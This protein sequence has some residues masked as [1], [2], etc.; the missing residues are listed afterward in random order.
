MRD[1]SPKRRTAVV[2]TGSGAS[3]AYHAGVL[4]ALDESGVKIDLVVGSGIGTLAA[5]FAAIAGGARLYGADG[6]WKAVGWRS[7]YRMRPILRAALWLLAAILAVIVVPAALALLVGLLSPLILLAWLIAS[8]F[9]DGVPRWVGLDLGSLPTLY[10]AALALPAFGLALVVGAFVARLFLRDRRRMAEAFEAILDERPAEERLRATLWTVARGPVVSA[11]APS[12]AELSK[13]YT[14]LLAENLGQPGFR[15][16]I[17]RAANLETC[18]A[19]PFVLLEDVHRAAFAAARSRGARV[20]GDGIPG[21][22][23]LRRAG[24]EGL[25]F[26][27]TMTG[28]LPLLGAPVRRIA[29]PRGGIHAGEVHRLADAALVGGSGLSEA[30][31]AGAQ[32]V[33][34]VTGVPGEALV[35]PRR[36]GPRALADGLLAALER[37]AVDRDVEGAE[38]INRMVETLGHRNE[39]GGRGWEDPATGR[40]YRDIALYVIRPE[41]RTLGPLELDGARDPASEVIE[42][43]DDLAERGYHDAYRLFVEPVVGGGEPAPRVDR[44]DAEG[45]PIEL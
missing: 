26:D 17:L 42:T 22:V 6:F 16:L 21:A 25:F 41:R 28:L 10:S 12:A 27:A 3:G 31:A 13:R 23:D 44:E 5:A 34:I 4:K 20:R 19:F 24:Y 37:R 8:H 15:E 35:P 33:I 39:D 29:F 32:Q 11:V 2:F 9:G 38:R 1:Y 43:L 30:L 18:S 7:L 45:Q 36:R 40:L 14:A